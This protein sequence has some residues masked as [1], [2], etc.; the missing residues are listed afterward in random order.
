VVAG[1]AIAVVALV[2]AVAV[3]RQ[4]SDERY[5][6]EDADPSTGWI[7]VPDPAPDQRGE[8]QGPP[9]EAT[10]RD[11]PY[12]P[13][14]HRGCPGPGFDA[15]CSGSQTLDVYRAPGDGDH[16]VVLWFHGGGWVAGDKN[17][18]AAPV[19]HLY[20]RGFDIVSA[21]YRLADGP[22]P[23]RYPA[24][25]HD[26][27]AAVRW[28]KANAEARGFNGDE[29]VAMGGS[30]GGYLVNMLATTAGQPDLEPGGLGPEQQEVDSDVAAAIAFAG[31]CDMC[32]FIAGTHGWSE[33]LL[34]ALLGCSTDC[35]EELL[36]QA[37]PTSHVTRDAAPLYAAN[38]VEDDLAP[39]AVTDLLGT[40]YD[41]AGVG[42]RLF[43][44]AVDTGDPSCRGHDPWCGTNAAALD[45]FVDEARER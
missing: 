41:R 3:G 44:D 20:G 4:L 45:R 43:D 25:V 39:P 12:L 32:A 22:R 11:I 19:L 36:V 34:D 38:G 16:P 2:V 1:I 8:P 26:A 23:A 29:I 10:E 31:V 40:A 5:D 27:K 17:N 30:A 35:S 33:P 6:I 15:D 37:S 24:A 7:E 42:H 13:G 18:L 9:P 14:A 21:N 28:V